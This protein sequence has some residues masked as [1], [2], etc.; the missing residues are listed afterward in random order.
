MQA[1]K[2]NLVCKG[3]LEITGLEAACVNG[4]GQ[5]LVR[6]QVNNRYYIRV[7]SRSSGEVSSEFPSKC[8][9]SSITCL[10]AHP[11]E[12]NFMSESC[13]VCEVIRNYDIQTGGYSIVYIGDT[14]FTIGNGP[15]GSL[16]TYRPQSGISLFKWHKEH[17]ELHASKSVHLEGML[18]QIC[19]SELF[20]M[21]VVVMYEDKV[22]KAVKLETEAATLTLSA[23]IWKLPKMVDGLVIKPDAVTSDKK[24]SVHVS[25]GAN[26]RILKINSL[27]GEVTSI[28]ILEEENI[29]PLR[30]LF[31]RLRGDISFRYLH[32]ISCRIMIIESSIRTLLIEDHPSRKCTLVQFTS[33]KKSKLQTLKDSIV[34]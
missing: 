11:T 7:M 26:N 2:I 33:S 31:K 29:I 19:Y 5:I 6:V 10:I 27:T 25:D 17:H 3:T 4:K 13:G 28:L 30:D 22:I 12:T 23:P 16:L 1:Q 24:E 20:N 18:N 9:H 14:P 34:L 32:S 21:L 15:T 8:E